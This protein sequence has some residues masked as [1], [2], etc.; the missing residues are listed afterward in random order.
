VRAVAL[1]LSVAVVVET[2]VAL[3]ESLDSETQRANAG[4]GRLRLLADLETHPMHAKRV[5][6]RR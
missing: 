4:A 1:A 3:F 5:R 2:L 6:Q